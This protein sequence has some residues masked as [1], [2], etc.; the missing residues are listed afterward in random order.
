MKK[1]LTIISV[2]YNEEKNLIKLFESLQ[3]IES[4]LSVKKI[5][6]DQSSTDISVEIAKQ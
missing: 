3:N 2:W 6:I 1:T 5:Y 4:I